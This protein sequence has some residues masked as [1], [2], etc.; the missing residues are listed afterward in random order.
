MFV[1]I[2]ERRFRLG[3]PDMIPGFVIG[4]AGCEADHL[5]PLG[6]ELAS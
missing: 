6:T 1:F 3:L 2:L 5:A 4:L